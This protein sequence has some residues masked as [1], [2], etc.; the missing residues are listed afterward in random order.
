MQKTGR[1]KARKGKKKHLERKNEPLEKYYIHRKKKEWND[2]RLS[3]APP[4]S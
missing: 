3:S 2:N 4:T 1:S